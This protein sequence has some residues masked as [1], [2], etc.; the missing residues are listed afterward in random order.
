MWRHLWRAI[1]YFDAGLYPVLCVNSKH[2][3]GLVKLLGIVEHEID[4]D[5]GLVGELH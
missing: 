4:L 3:A 5:A 2:E 1:G